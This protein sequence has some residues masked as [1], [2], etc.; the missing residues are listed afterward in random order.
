ML[1]PTSD[2]AA[3]LVPGLVSVTFRQLGAWE[4]VRLA[5]E[6]KLRSI[7]WGG[8]VHVPHGDLAT[9]SEV[10]KITREYGIEVAAYGSY[11]RAGESESRDMPFERVLETAHTLG[12]S[13]I[14]VWAGAKASREADAEYWD[15][16]VSDS[17]HISNL[18]HASGIRLA[19]EYHA[20]T[21]MDSE[22]SASRLLSEMTHPAMETLWQP[23]NGQS[24]DDCL[25]SLERILPRLANI[26]V[27]HWWPD[28]NHRLPLY[29]GADR[30][31]RYIAIAASQS[32]CRHLL[33]EFVPEDNPQLLSG[34]AETLLEWIEQQEHSIL[35]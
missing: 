10:G 13:L 6:C 30:W 3:E 20:N 19:F 31:K 8:D 32:G 2:S 29:T 9:A 14:R 35:A 28:S 33:L 15:H 11:Y 23:P 16:V 18:A 34:E 7:E 12:A 21:L 22:L 25:R 17:L 26:H 5:S 24:L 4:I 1:S 27:F